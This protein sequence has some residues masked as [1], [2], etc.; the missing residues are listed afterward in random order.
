M[1]RK[2]VLI[3]AA[4]PAGLLVLLLATARYG[5]DRHGV[6]YIS[7]PP[8][9]LIEWGPNRRFIVQEGVNIVPDPG[10]A[11][12]PGNVIEFSISPRTRVSIRLL[13]RHWVRQELRAW[14]SDHPRV[15]GWLGVNPCSSSSS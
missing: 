12:A 10:S 9:A 8:I 1:R 4:I 2:L 3:G 11:G 15:A 13:S 14:A 5:D 7:R 6:R